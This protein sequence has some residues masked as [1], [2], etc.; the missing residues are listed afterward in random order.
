MPLQERTI[1]VGDDAFIALHHVIP[2]DL[3]FKKRAVRDV[4]AYLEDWPHEENI[5]HRN[6]IMV[7]ALA[8]KEM[9]VAACTEP[10]RWLLAVDCDPLPQVL[11][12]RLACA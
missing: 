10:Q 8:T 1:D 2:M 11:A 6:V 7:G 4:K 12:C 3:A 5:I 9:M